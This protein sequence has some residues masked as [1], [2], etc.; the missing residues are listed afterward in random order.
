M[1]VIDLLNKIANGEKVPEKIKWGKHY[2]T[3]FV[4]EHKA[5]DELGNPN[6]FECAGGGISRR[7]LNDEIEIIEDTSKEEIQ[8]IARWYP[9]T[10]YKKIAKIGKLNQ[11]SDNKQHLNNYIL[12]NKINEIIDRLNDEF[13][14]S[15]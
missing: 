6:I 14:E 13:K 5:L 2:L 8:V 4:Y 1:K 3:W 10:A 9:P 7:L 15:N 11:V 12:R